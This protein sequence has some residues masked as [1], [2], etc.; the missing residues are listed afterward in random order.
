MNN[1]AQV[2]PCGKCFEVRMSGG[3]TRVLGMHKTK[4]AAE[5]QALAINF[6]RSQF[7]YRKDARGS[8]KVA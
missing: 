1:R 7:D 6:R 5:A 3:A 2:Y 8:K 4:Q